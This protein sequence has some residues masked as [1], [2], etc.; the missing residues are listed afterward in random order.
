MTPIPSCRATIESVR[1]Q[2]PADRSLTITMDGY[3]IRLLANDPAITAALKGYFSPF[4]SPDGGD[5]TAATI[6]VHE[7]TPPLADVPFTVKPPDPGKE[8]IKEE[9][10]ALADGR[11]VRKR[12]T[13]MVFLFS[14]NDHLAVGPC[15]DNLNQVIN[16]VNNRFIQ[17]KLCSGSLL[18]HAA[19]ISIDGR[20][21]AMAGFSGAGKS[22]LALE[23]MRRPDCIFISNDRLMIQPRDGGLEMTGVA[24]LP[25]INPGTALNNPNLSS[26]LSP[27]DKARFSSLPESELW[28][29]EHK[30]DVPL[31]Q[32]FGPERF[33]LKAT[34]KGLVLLNWKR[35]QDPL[36]VRPVV[37]SERRDLLP[38]FMKSTGLFFLESDA[39]GMP[40][41]TEDAYIDMLSRCKVWEF[42]GGA[43]FEGAGRQCRKLLESP[44]SGSAA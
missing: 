39:C 38:A 25:R 24:K 36:T 32:C 12:L 11:C 18:G 2:L 17:W 13:G 33:S 42:S 26:I 37:L 7:G 31:D 1:R 16:F 34:M 3:T 44:R 22:T 20:G 6:T 8:K 35:N 4:L 30:Y 14:E 10:L 29:L 19:G 9:F 21:L 43:D 15:L 23:L 27:E 41:P 40:E 5:E 28:D